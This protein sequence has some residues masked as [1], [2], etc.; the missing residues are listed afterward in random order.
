MKVIIKDMLGT[1]TA[2]AG[3]KVNRI[4]SQI[5]KQSTKHLNLPYRTG[6]R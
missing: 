5:T 3:K 1:V 4:G 2:A 6:K